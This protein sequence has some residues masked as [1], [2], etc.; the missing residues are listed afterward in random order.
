MEHGL[1]S[2]AKLATGKT[3]GAGGRGM[4]NAQW[5]LFSFRTKIRGEVK[6]KERN[7][8]VK[9]QGCDDKKS[10]L[11]LIKFSR[12]V[13]SC[14]NGTFDEDGGHHCLASSK[15]RVR[16]D[17]VIGKVNNHILRIFFYLDPILLLFSLSLNTSFDIVPIF[18]QN[19]LL[20]FTKEM[21]RCLLMSKH[22]EYFDSR[23]SCM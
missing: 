12:A 13:L 15:I 4:A 1:N 8:V 3:Y 11:V 14:E 22:R 21:D 6:R 9:D 18:V 23:N 10:L 5:I 19:G 16:F 17:R 2:V 20:L 7:L